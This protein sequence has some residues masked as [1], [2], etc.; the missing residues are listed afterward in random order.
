MARAGYSV[1]AQTRTGRGFQGLHTHLHRASHLKCQHH[2]AVRGPERFLHVSQLTTRLISQSNKPQT[3]TPNRPM[4]PYKC[5]SKLREFS[6]L[7]ATPSVCS[8]Q[9]QADVNDLHR[10]HPRKTMG[11]I[12][13][14]MGGDGRVRKY[15]HVRSPRFPG[16]RISSMSSQRKTFRSC[17]TLLCV[18]SLC[19]SL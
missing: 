14:Q 15:G 19:W 18:K 3:P 5:L 9:R 6:R 11:R 1:T 2:K 17:L 16:V 12:S 4:G 13:K 10:I 7:T 8:A